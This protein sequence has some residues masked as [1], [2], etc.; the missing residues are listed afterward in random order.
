MKVLFT[1][2]FFPKDVEYIRERT[3]DKIT[4]L[5][6]HDFDPD[7]LP[8]LVSE[9][10]VLFGGL[11]SEE[12]LKKGKLLKYIQIPWTGVDNLNWDLIS[13]FDIP[14]CNSH[15]NSYVVAEHAVTLMMDAAKKISY[16][17]RNL[18]NDNWNRL[19]PGIENEISP[20]STSIRNSKIGIL[21]FGSIGKSICKL[22]SGFDCSFKVFNRSGKSSITD[23]NVEIF[24][25]DHLLDQISD[26][27]FLY[28]T[29]PLTNETK[30]LVNKKVLDLLPTHAVLIN[31]SR[32]TI[33]NEKDLFVALKEK[34]IGW[35]AIDTWYNYPN[36]K[37]QKVPPSKNFDFGKLE[38]ITLSPHRAGYINSGFPHLDDAIEN[39]NRALNGEELINV[40]S[41]KNRY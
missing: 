31:V 3:S 6:A 23:S 4:Y 10:D 35:A 22:L 15:S 36:V 14:V 40:L 1:K 28:V 5:N 9:A 18:R 7:K 29:L 24:A 32:G 37:N 21:G 17:D 39:L 38:N 11:I 13:S 20:F 19:F 30:G 26:L 2:K 27:D 12:L 25:L 41:L 8:E 16:H 34:N 33:V